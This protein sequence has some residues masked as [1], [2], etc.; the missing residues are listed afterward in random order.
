M[1]AKIFEGGFLDNFS[2]SGEKLKKKSHTFFP[3]V[4]FSTKAFFANIFFFA[5]KSSNITFHDQARNAKKNLHIFFLTFF[6]TGDFFFI[7][8]FFFP[9]PFTCMRHEEVNR[10]RHILTCAIHRESFL[11]PL[12][13]ELGSVPKGLNLTQPLAPKNF[14]RRVRHEEV[15]R[16]RH[17]LACAIYPRVPWAGCLHAPY[18]C[19]RHVFACAIYKEQ[20]Y[21]G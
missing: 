7:I 17:I 19:V 9:A 4:F 15:N 20:P 5:Q 6:S 16:V 8:N 10:V 1:C 18:I 14:P 3:Q 11:W 13:V 12:K 21:V 2:W